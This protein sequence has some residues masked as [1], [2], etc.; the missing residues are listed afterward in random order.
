MA[1]TEDDAPAGTRQPFM[2][3][4]QWALFGGLIVVVVILSVAL[5]VTLL[6]PAVD[7]DR[8]SRGH[9]V[10]Q[11][12]AL[13]DRMAFYERELERLEQAREQEQQA[14]IPPVLLERLV[15]QEE[16]LREFIGSLQS[17]MEELAHMVQGSREWLEH[18]NDQLEDVMARSEERQQEL[19]QWQQ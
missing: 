3:T 13:E 10:D 8:E 14:S 18:Y 2:S 6:G 12:S 4:G 17:G 19:E 7:R 5:T 9:L 16:S 11:I 15:D 1:D